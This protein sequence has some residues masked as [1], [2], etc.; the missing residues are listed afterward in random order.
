MSI[1]IVNECLLRRIAMA[2]LVTKINDNKIGIK[3]NYSVGRIRKVKTIEGRQW[4][5]EIGI[6][7]IPY[8]TNI[9]NTIKD[10]FKNEQIK[11]DFQFKLNSGLNFD[12]EIYI[13]YV[14]NKLRLKGYSTAT[15]KSY[16]SHLKR[17]SSYFDKDFKNLVLADVEKYLLFLIQSQNDSHAYINQ[18]ISAIKILCTEVLK[19]TDIT[20]NAP[21]PKKEKKLPNVLSRNDVIKILSSLNPTFG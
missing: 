17:F 5:P 4:N 1:L 13:K 9:I 18:A 11:F 21:R 7:T 15:I 2:I 12:N 19:K 16:I 20:V 6:W 3:F 10:L 8:N 14:E